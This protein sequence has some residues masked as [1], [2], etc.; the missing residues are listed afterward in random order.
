MNLESAERSTQ[1][2]HINGRD[3]LG[4]ER[5]REGDLRLSTHEFSP[6]CTSRQGHTFAPS[7]RGRPY[8]REDVYQ[9]AVSILSQ[10]SMFE[11]IRF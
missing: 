6:L 7:I 3:I 9:Q 11:E 4:V 5:V 8:V 10:S 2:E 1:L